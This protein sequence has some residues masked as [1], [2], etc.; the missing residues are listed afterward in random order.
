LAI[1]RAAVCSVI[2]RLQPDVVIGHDPWRSYRVHPDHRHAA[3]NS[4]FHSLSA[5]LL[6][7]WP[8]P[9]HGPKI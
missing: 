8:R 3:E 4:L 2:R 6:D 9:D 5:G 7:L 1:A